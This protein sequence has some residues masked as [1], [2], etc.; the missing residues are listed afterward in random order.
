[1][2]WSISIQVQMRRMLFLIA[3]ILLSFSA[4]NRCTWKKNLYHQTTKTKQSK[5]NSL[6]ITSLIIFLVQLACSHEIK[7]ML[8]LSSSYI[9]QKQTN[10]QKKWSF[11]HYR[12]NR[13]REYHSHKRKIP[14]KKYFFFFAILQGK[15][16][17]VNKKK[18][19]KNTNS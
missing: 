1:M 10:K 15:L 5:K 13:A 17:N 3:I 19:K 2:W 8:L 12:T 11:K 4:M 7:K 14:E 6:I 9:Y 16:L 18:K